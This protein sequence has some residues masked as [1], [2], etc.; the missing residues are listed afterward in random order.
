MTRMEPFD[1][2]D[3]IRKQDTYSSKDIE[4]LRALAILHPDEP[5]QWD[6]LGDIMQACDEAL[7][8]E[9]SMDCY[10]RAIE[11]DETYAPAYE[12]I[13]WT[14]DSYFDDFAGAEKNFLLA[15]QH[16]SGDSARIGL[17]R[18]LA[19]TG[20]IEAALDNLAL[21][22]DQSRSA[23]IDMRREIVE[24]VWFTNASEKT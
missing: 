23:V 4:E 3:R 9:H 24:G 7:P 20:R 11:C 1:T 19:Q 5:E 6:F 10:N 15:L 17:S 2:I 21:C 18:V 8:I 13:G 16:G 12:S 22:E 14:L